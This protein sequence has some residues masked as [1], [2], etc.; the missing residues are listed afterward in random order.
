V[1]WPFFRGFFFVVSFPWSP[2]PWSLFD[3]LF[4]V[5]PSQKWS[6]FMRHKG[7]NKWLLYQLLAPLLAPL[8]SP[9]L[10]ALL[11]GLFLINLVECGLADKPLRLL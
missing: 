11:R 8:C 5:V 10:R 7:P 6:L 9:F 3:G 1:A 4:S 2:F